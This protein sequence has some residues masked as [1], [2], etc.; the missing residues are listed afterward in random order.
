MDTKGVIFAGLVAA[1]ALTTPSSAVNAQ[2]KSEPNTAQDIA[3]H[4]P[5]HAGKGDGMMMNHDGRNERM[6]RMR[7]HRQRMMKEMR[8]CMESMKT[9][10]PRAPMSQD[11][12]REQLMTQM[13]GCMDRMAD[14]MHKKMHQ[15]D[16]GMMGKGAAGA[17]HH[18]KMKDSDGSP[19][20]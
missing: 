12:M 3:P 14:K 15:K 10:K 11:Q 13:E 8:T 18:E 17:D 7:K 6:K 20:Q 19:E 5:Q 16:G 4:M 9:E 2:T 1:L